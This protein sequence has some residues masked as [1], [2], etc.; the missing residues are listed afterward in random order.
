MTIHLLS[1]PIRERLHPST[2]ALL[3]SV[4]AGI[5][6]PEPAPRYRARKVLRKQVDK[7]Q[8]SD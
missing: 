6:A 3:A 4:T 5:P 2:L 7:N 1:L 8:P